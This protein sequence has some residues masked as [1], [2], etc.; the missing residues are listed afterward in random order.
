MAAK[1]RELILLGFL[2]SWAVWDLCFNFL[3]FFGLVT[4]AEKKKMEPDIIEDET[5]HYSWALLDFVF[6]FLAYGPC[7]NNKE[8]NGTGH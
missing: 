7:E 6:I 8:N 5:A 1:I 2:A 3:C 4:W